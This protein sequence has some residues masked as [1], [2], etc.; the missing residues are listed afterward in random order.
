LKLSLSSLPVRSR[1]SIF[2]IIWI[3]TTL[4]LAWLLLKNEPAFASRSS[5]VAMGTLFICTLGLIWQ[6]SNPIPEEASTLAGKRWRFILLIVL[7]CVVLFPLRTLVGPPLLFGLPVIGLLV[8]AWLHW[9]ISL[10]SAI[11]ASN[12]ALIAGIAGLGAG[13]IKDI[14]LPAW[15]V[16]NFLL[17]LT[18]LLAGWG[19]LQRYGLDQFGIGHS[20]FLAEGGLQALK[21]FGLGLLLALPWAFGSVLMG[22]SQSETWLNAWWQPLTAIQPGIAE[23]VWGRILIVPLL[24][25]LLR[26]A[27]RSRQAFTAALLIGACWFAYLHTPGGIS[28]LP[29]MLIIGT[30][31]TL[32]VSYL[33]L[34][35]D[36]ETAIGFH[37]WLDFVKFLYALIFVP[38]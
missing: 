4:L 11:Y 35:L 37:F 6:L 10:R 38:G 33:C 1:R 16:L 27:A 9:P 13:W 14:P 19:I 12:L 17:T 20:R 29:S 21:S 8:L 25:V 18:G 7:I 24:F 36:L 28:A 3:I 23:E 32:P 5:L 15:A 2:A 31:F 34:H 26:N 30:L 22:S